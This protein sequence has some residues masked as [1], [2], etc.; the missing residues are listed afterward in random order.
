M[1]V[2][3]VEHRRSVRSIVIDPVERPLAVMY[4]YGLECPYG[5]FVLHSNSFL[6]YYSLFID[7]CKVYSSDLYSTPAFLPEVPS[8]HNPLDTIP[9]YLTTCFRIFNNWGIPN[10]LLLHY[11]ASLEALFINELC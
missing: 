11:N 2:D 9:S 6:E 7:S 1:V 8:Q 10:M 4:I 5:A 3:P